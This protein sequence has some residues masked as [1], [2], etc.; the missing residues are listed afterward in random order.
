MT[1]VLAEVLAQ[2]TQRE[3]PPAQDRNRCTNTYRYGQLHDAFPAEQWH[4]LCHTVQSCS[5]Q[6]ARFMAAQLRCVVC[7]CGTR[8]QKRH[9]VSCTLQQ[10]PLSQRACFRTASVAE[11]SRNI[12]YTS[13]MSTLS[14]DSQANMGTNSA[15]PQRVQRRQRWLTHRPTLHAR[16]HR[17][18][19]VAHLMAPFVTLAAAL[20]TGPAEF[21]I[22]FLDRHETLN[23]LNSG[24]KT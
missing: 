17:P 16:C 4:T 10:P 20:F 13:P 3:S 15:D 24:L 19:K 2:L 12:R 6:A 7:G 1:L 14:Y 18:S 21:I 5:A 11:G 23:S 9:G 22:L 8:A